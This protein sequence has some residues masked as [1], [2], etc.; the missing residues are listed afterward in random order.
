MPPVRSLIYAQSV[1]A[2]DIRQQVAGEM[3]LSHAAEQSLDWLT[4]F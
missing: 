1:T 3:E 4:F 2:D